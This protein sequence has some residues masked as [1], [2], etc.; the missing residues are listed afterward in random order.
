MD[1]ARFQSFRVGAVFR[2]FAWDW[3]ELKFAEIVGQFWAEIRNK[4]LDLRNEKGVKI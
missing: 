2:L 3:A 1:L 4:W